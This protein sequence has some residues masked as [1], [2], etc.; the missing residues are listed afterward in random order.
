MLF[1]DP[2]GHEIA[3]GWSLGEPFKVELPRPAGRAYDRDGDEILLDKGRETVEVSASP[4]Y[5]HLES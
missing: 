2:H 3:V 1:E 5:F 4:T